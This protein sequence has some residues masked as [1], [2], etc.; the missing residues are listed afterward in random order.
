VLRLGRSAELLKLIAQLHRQLR[1][2]C[3]L[4]P[5]LNALAEFGIECE[6]FGEEVLELSL[7]EDHELGV[8][9]GDGA[10]DRAL[11]ELVGAACNFRW[12]AGSV[13]FE[14][15]TDA[16][17]LFVVLSGSVQIV[18]VRDGREVEIARAGP[19]NFFGEQSLLLRRMHS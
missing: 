18:D 3:L 8:L 16:E 2:L 5:C 6:A 13:V 14:A 15:G 7:G 19:G 9:A 12:H 10:L 1:A 4:R 11:L 17:A